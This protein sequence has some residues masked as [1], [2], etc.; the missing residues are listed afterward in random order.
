[1][2]NQDSQTT[3][4]VTAVGRHYKE[5]PPAA[6]GSK[7]D[8]ETIAEALP[9]VASSQDYKLTYGV[10]ITKMKNISTGTNLAGVAF[11]S[12]LGV[13]SGGDV[14]SGSRSIHL[15]G[16]SGAYPGSIT[17]TS[18]NYASLPQGVV[19]CLR[20]ANGQN[21]EITVGANASDTSI[22]T[23]LDTGVGKCG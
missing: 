23:Q 21:A 22:V 3:R 9:V 17:T 18:G 4:L 1:M 12:E 10:T 14:V 13:K 2:I 6:A 7:I 11:Y 16:L 20:G 5:I 8:V 19:F 15:Y